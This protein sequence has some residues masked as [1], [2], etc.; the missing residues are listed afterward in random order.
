M[1]R[2]SL[3]YAFMLFHIGI[4]EVIL[5]KAYNSYEDF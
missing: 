4:Y 1:I 3:K 2:V 5:T